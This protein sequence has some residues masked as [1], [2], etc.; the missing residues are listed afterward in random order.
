MNKKYNINNIP[1]LAEGIK[2]AIQ[3]AL[4]S[5][6]IKST[7]EYLISVP[8]QLMKEIKAQK[9]T[10]FYSYSAGTPIGEDLQKNWGTEWHEVYVEE[11]DTY[12]Y[13]A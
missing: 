11:I 13:L 8:E 1:N 12:F 10:A 4:F 7:K 2:V 3:E 6:V 5:D 9:Y